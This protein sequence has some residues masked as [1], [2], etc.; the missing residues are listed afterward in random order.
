MTPHVM[1]SP[2]GSGIPPE[3]L[4]TS[5][6]D[7]V[8]TQQ[9]L[10]YHASFGLVACLVIFSS[11]LLLLGT[12][13]AC[14]S[15]RIVVPDIFHYVSSFTRDNPYIQA[16]N[17]GSDLDGVK[18][19]HSLRKLHVQGSEVEPDAGAGYPTV[20]KVKGTENR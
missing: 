19:S 12:I 7:A 17:G 18:H 1:I 13:S 6:T 9:V 5:A 11:V 3:I 10:I 20:R 4:T 8:V 16:P 15:L 2:D 14:S